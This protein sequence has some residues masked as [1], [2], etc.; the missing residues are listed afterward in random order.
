MRALCVYA[1]WR[2]TAGR[3]SVDVFVSHLP[4][5][6]ASHSWPVDCN[7][8]RS[9][10]LSR[11]PSAPHAN[12]VLSLGRRCFRRPP[13]GSSVSELSETI[14]LAMAVNLELRFMASAT[15]NVGEN[16]GLPAGLLSPRRRPRQ[17][18]H[19]VGHL[20]QCL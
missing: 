2:E 11:V 4:Y 15:Q 9:A 8:A 19:E 20:C 3:A 7:V 1:I 13:T 6:R 18:R 17:G 16:T 12:R 14:G 10:S 5:P